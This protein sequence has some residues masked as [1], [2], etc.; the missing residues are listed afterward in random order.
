LKGSLF[1]TVKVGR[2]YGV[3][4]VFSASASTTLVQCLV[5]GPRR[6]RLTTAKLR[7]DTIHSALC[8]RPCQ[9]YPS[10]GRIFFFLFLPVIVPSEHECWK[11]D[12]VP[13][14]NQNRTRQPRGTAPTTTS[15]GKMKK[16]P[17]ETLQ[18]RSQQPNKNPVSRTATQLTAPNL[19]KPRPY[20]RNQ[21]QQ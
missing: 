18:K 9:S 1:A 5:V 13:A 21:H 16:I 3:L 11:L 14:K 17:E 6:A 7:F 2:V 8:I 4:R 15:A 19:S 10:E 20:Y 12:A